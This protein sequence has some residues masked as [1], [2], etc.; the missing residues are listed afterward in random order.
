MTYK[1]EISAIKKLNKSYRAQLEIHGNEEVKEKLRKS[2]LRNDSLLQVLQR[3]MV[4]SF[5]SL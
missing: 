5:E 4:V 3:K 1:H 2:V